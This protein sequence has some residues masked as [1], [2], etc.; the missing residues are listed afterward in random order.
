MPLSRTV[1]QSGGDDRDA[2]NVPRATELKDE[3]T[4]DERG[5]Y[6]DLTTGDH[7]A[8]SVGASGSLAPENVHE[9][10]N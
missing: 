3:D 7:F 9:R 4:D 8:L 10:R 5:V 1:E 2:D 6:P